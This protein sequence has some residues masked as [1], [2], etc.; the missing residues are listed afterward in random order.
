MNVLARVPTAALG[1]LRCASNRRAYCSCSQHMH[2]NGLVILNSINTSAVVTSIEKALSLCTDT[3]FVDLRQAPGC[4]T[5]IMDVVGTIYGC[6]AGLAPC[7]NVV[8][9]LR[10]HYPPGTLLVPNLRN[11]SYSLLVNRLMH[12]YQLQ[13]TLFLL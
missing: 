13:E 6:V 2:S 11:E 7:R 9:L 12:F 4:G 3:V 5:G 1:H 8:P 10:N